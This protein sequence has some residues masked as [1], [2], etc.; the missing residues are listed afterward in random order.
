MFAMATAV[1]GVVYSVN[2]RKKRETKLRNKEKGMFLLSG[3]LWAA[4]L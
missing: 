4:V 2:A 3:L 1:T